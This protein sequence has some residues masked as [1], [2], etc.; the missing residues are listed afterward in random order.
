MSFLGDIFGGGDVS[1]PTL[2]TIDPNQILSD[3]YGQDFDKA[4]ST[5]NKLTS[6]VSSGNLDT[7]TNL[8]AKI[9]PS[10]ASNIKSIGST[11]SALLSGSTASLPSWLSA[12]MDKIQRQGAEGAAARGLGAYSGAGQSAMRTYAGD[13]GLELYELGVNLSN[14]AENSANTIASKAYTP[15]NVGDALLSTG[16]L[17][18]IA[19]ANAGI[20]N[21]QAE[22]EAQ[23]SNYNANNSP[24]GNALQQVLSLGTTLGGTWLGSYF[25]TSGKKAAGG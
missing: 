1:A 22:A 23:A 19:G 17:S 2:S 20:K 14:N 4:I 13:K 12:Y 15:Y 5:T 3:Y 6:G 18:S 9:N 11:A 25:S 8:L 24:L 16:Q 7:Y 10:G 21:T